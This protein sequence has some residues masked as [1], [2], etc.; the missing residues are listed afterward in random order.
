MARLA[1]PRVVRGPRQYSRLRKRER[2]TRGRAL[3]A[4]SYMRRDRLSLRA[5]ARKAGTTPGTVK[6]YAGTE[7]KQDRRRGRY[8]IT[9]GDRLYRP[10]RVLTNVG[11][12]EVG[13]SG[14][15]Q[16]SLI[17]AYWNAVDH[18]LRSGDDS[19]LRG[20]AG[21]SVAGVEFETDLTVIDELASRGE[22][23]F[24]SIYELAA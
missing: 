24:E 5:A 11:I 21:R 2:Q 6:R 13:V 18:Y 22:L 14:S 1:V 10:M 16:A 3:E 8:T 20:F 15:R 17:G 12:V 7:L 19:T 9:G 4:V 23:E